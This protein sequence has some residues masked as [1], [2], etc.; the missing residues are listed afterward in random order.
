VIR[1]KEDL[2]SAEAFLPLL[3]FKRDKEVD[4]TNKTSKN[5]IKINPMKT[6]L[7]KFIKII[8]AAASQF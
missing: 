7:I 3:K 6:H 1:P 8:K 5:L 4:L 2:H